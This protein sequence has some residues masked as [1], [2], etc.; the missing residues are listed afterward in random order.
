MTQRGI[1]IV[2]KGCLQKMNVNV[3]ELMSKTNCVS[4]P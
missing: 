3:S 2:C 4:H 1:E